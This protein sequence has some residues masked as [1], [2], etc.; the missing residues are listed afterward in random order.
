MVLDVFHQ[1]EDYSEEYVFDTKVFESENGKEYRTSLISD[2]AVKYY[3]LKFKT[4]TSQDLKKL[5]NY[6]EKTIDDKI[7]LKFF[8]TETINSRT[9]GDSYITVNHKR[10][11]YNNDV[12]RLSYGDIIIIEDSLNPNNIE[13]CTVDNVEVI[14]ETER[15][16]YIY[17]GTPNDFGRN[18][19]VFIKRECEIQSNSVS[20]NE[21]FKRFG[22]VSL[23]FKDVE[24]D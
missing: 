4:K 2:L 17:Y 16:I 3:Y 5:H 24:V 15:R 10:R 7:T 19:K 8:E 18:S 22:E 9:S 1:I 13:K 23:K 11:I 6:I 14:S 21:Q 12:S 20:I